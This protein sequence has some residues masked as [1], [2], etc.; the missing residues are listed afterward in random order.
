MTVQPS[1]QPS[2]FIRFLRLP[3]GISCQMSTDAPLIEHEPCLLLDTLRRFPPLEVRPPCSTKQ[4]QA[5][6]SLLLYYSNTGR[7][8]FRS[9]ATSKSCSDLARSH[10]CA[11]GCYQLRPY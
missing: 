5:D 6:R 3:S 4:S 2:R 1:W 11:Q 10:M 7:T 8:T 9:L